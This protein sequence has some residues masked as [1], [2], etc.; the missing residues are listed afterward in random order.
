MSE[1]MQTGFG[2]ALRRRREELRLSLDDV[3]AS[4]RIRKTYLQALEEENLQALPGAAYS[5][6]FLRI[7]ARQLGLPVEPLI[8]S[9]SVAGDEDEH[10]GAGGLGGD[11]AASS[12]RGRRRGKGGRLGLIL[13]LLVLLV[14]AGA[15]VYLYLRPA[16]PA[17]APPPPPVAKEPQVSP[18][19]E[20]KPQPAVP[21]AP[22]P[23]QAPAA[24]QPAVTATE[25]PV[26]PPGG[27]V[28]R[29][30]P[31]AA[32]VM[33]VSLDG[34]EVR[35]YQLQPDQSLNWKVAGSLSCELSVPGL[36]KVWVDQKEVAVVEYQAFILKTV[37]PQGQRP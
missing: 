29:M 37:S 7:Y 31:V 27:A 35:E 16:P 17:V 14:V 26:L 18:V 24:D 6:G 28:V 22:V 34:Q 36:V 21:A 15:A 9:R 4:T 23:P 5:I 8:H 32:G 3:A 10:G 13:S 2:A 30:L 12:K 19:I 25:L 33:K 11:Q 1:I 20:S